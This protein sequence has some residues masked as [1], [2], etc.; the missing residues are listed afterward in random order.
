MVHVLPAGLSGLHGALVE[1]MAVSHRAVRRVGAHR[2]DLVAVHGAGPIGLGTILALRAGGLRSVVAD[3]SPTRRAAATR[4]GADHVLDPTADDV[5]DAVR[6]LTGGLGAAGAIDAAGAPSAVQAALRSTRPDG[7]V[8]LVGHHAQ[9][10]ALRSGSLIFSEVKVTG[11]HI[12]DQ[13]DIRAVIG[14][15]VTGGYPI[16]GWTSTI[17]LEG[18]VD[19]GLVPLREQGVNKVLVRPG[20]P[21]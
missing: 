15:M 6:D 9:P 13:S 3:P 4:L 16:E 1:P 21:G 10:I 7:T 20:A 11:S 8:V 19:E 2:G 14:A 5:A 12:Y 18:V 17:A